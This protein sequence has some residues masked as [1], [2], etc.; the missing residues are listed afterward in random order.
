MTASEKA[1]ETILQELQKGPASGTDLMA[2]TLFGASTIYPTLR[3]MKDRGTLVVKEYRTGNRVAAGGGRGRLRIYYEIAQDSRTCRHLR[4][5]TTA[6]VPEGSGTEFDGIIPLVVTVLCQDCGL[7]RH[8][9]MDFRGF[10][11]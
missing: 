3:L 6:D 10:R 8:E 11:S 1:Q 7:L 2:R 5:T 9:S 4:L